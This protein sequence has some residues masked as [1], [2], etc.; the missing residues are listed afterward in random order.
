MIALVVVVQR[1]RCSFDSLWLRIKGSSR[2][3]GIHIVTDAR[4]VAW[5]LGYARPL[6]LWAGTKEPGSDVD[7]NTLDLCR[8]IK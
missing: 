3:E 8:R 2:G 6:D 1:L 5:L 4:E 7:M